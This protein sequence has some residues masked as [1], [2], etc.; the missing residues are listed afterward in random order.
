MEYTYDDII[1]AKDIL[2]GRVKKEDIIGQSGWF[3]DCIPEDM[4]LNVIARIGRFGKLININSD[5]S[6]PFFYSEDG[7]EYYYIYFL[8]ERKESA[9]KEPIIEDFSIGDR[10]VLLSPA[11][12]IPEYLVGKEGRIVSKGTFYLQLMF[13]GSN[14]VWGTEP[15]YLRKVEDNALKQA[16]IPEPQLSGYYNSRKPEYAPFD[17]SREE[18]RQL[19]RDTWIKSKYNGNEARISAFKHDETRGWMAHIP[20]TGMRDGEQL[21]NSYTFLDGSPCGKQIASK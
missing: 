7:C 14:E 6:Y 13:D 15:K 19:L 4:S 10:V 12:F 20:Q 16:D 8:P 9:P 11:H 17:L 5:V 1:T 21:F 2:T 18:D 3:M